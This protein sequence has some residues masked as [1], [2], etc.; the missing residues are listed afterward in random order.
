ME[1]TAEKTRYITILRHLFSIVM[2][3]F[4]SDISHYDIVL[5]LA[6][7]AKNSLWIGT[8]DIKDLYVIQGQTEKPF[9]GILSELIGH[10]VEVRLIH[11]KEPGPNFCK[12]FDKYP[13]LARMLERVLCPRVHF[14]I[15]IIDQKICYIG[16]ANLTGAG[17]GMKSAYRRNFE[18]G[19]L[20]DNSDIVN[21]AFEEFDKVWRG[22]ECKK[23]Q[24]RKFCIDPIA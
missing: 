4:L 23:C 10:G 5:N 14:K 17:M 2:Y 16:S 21:A 1:S 12:D 3:N 22:S 15:I 7:Q 19:I 9:L 20:T 18:A 13:S 8:A 11:A 24:R 6:I